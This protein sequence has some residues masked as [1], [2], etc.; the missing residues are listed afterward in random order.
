MV[1]I[2]ADEKEKMFLTLDA[3]RAGGKVNMFGAGLS[4]EDIY[5]LSRSQARAVLVEWMETFG[6]RQKKEGSDATTR[7]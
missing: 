2:P 1:E 5:G 3:I 7:S 6:T 4:L